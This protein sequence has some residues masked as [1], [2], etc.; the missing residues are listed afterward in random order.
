MEHY[1]EDMIDQLIEEALELKKNPQ[2][3]FEKGKLFGYYEVISKLLNDAEAFGISDK[4]PSKW[5]DFIP[6]ELLSNM[7]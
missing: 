2:D 1:I 6:E 4:L 3:E 7:G 5:R